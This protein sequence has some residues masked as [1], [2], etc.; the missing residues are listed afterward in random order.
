MLRK[1]NWDHNLAIR[2]ILWSGKWR[3]TCIVWEHHVD[4][5]PANYVSVFCMKLCVSGGSHV[6]YTYM[7]D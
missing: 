1:S 2:V 6:K 7:I 3:N 4:V 5:L